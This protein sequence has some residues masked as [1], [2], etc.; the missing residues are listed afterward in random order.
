M[1]DMNIEEDGF[2]SRRV[3]RQEEQHS[4]VIFLF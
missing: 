4:E 1:A 3:V 2:V